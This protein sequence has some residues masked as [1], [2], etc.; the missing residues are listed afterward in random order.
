MTKISKREIIKTPQLSKMVYAKR[1]SDAE[2]KAIRPS[3]PTL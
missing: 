3:K 1:K 2:R